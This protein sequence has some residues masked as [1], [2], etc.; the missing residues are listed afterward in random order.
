VADY[1]V[2]SLEDCECRRAPLLDALTAL[3][4]TPRVVLGVDGRKGLDGAAENLIERQEANRRAKRVVTD[5]ELACALS[6]LEVYRVILEQGCQHAVVLE[7]D[8]RL[9]EGFLEA[10]TALERQD[11]DIALLDH[12]F[13]RSRWLAE[14][15]LPTG[16]RVWRVTN[17]PDR[18]TGY[19]VTANAA[20]QLLEC[21]FPVRFLA[22]WPYDISTLVT[23]AVSPSVV[24]RSGNDQDSLLAGERKRSQARAT[25][26]RPSPPYSDTGVPARLYRFLSRRIS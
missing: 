4:I 8:A 22:D 13:A 19:I 2:L 18:N 11:F 1:F 24:I 26:G 23:L 6:H 10:V 21:S 25:W 14:F 16:A 3:G 17:I 20:R 12:E 15:N 5:G 9:T 7:D